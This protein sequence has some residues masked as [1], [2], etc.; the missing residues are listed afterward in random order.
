MVP[1]EHFCD[2]V[3]LVYHKGDSNDFAKYGPISLLVTLYK[4]YALML[5]ARLQTPL[6]VPYFQLN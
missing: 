1:E 6:G 2:C 3:V 4:L 5:R